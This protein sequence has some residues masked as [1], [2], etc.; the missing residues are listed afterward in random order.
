M[1]WKIQET[2]LHTVRVGGTLVSLMSNA[3]KLTADKAW[4]GYFTTTSFNMGI[5]LF[6]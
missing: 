2:V 6:H 4:P 1:I 5:L 3:K